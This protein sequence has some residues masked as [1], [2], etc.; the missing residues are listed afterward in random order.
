MNFQEFEEELITGF[1]NP[2]FCIITRQGSPRAPLCMFSS[3]FCFLISHSS[4]GGQKYTGIGG[5]QG[6]GSTEWVI[7]EWMAD[8]EG[9]L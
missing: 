8:C 4:Q 6:G 1:Y 9:E 7:G 5:G 3:L 2:V